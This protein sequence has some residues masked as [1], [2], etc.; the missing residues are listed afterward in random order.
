[1]FNQETEDERVGRHDGFNLFNRQLKDAAEG[2][3]PGQ[4]SKASSDALQRGTVKYFTSSAH[5]SRIF[6][7][8]AWMSLADSV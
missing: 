4:A 2:F 5:A 8:V 7:A 3:Q 6:W 1:M